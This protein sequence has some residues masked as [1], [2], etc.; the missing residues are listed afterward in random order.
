MCL[1]QFY[2][3]IKIKFMKFGFEMRIYA[4]KS[5]F[6]FFLNCPISANHTNTG[7][8]NLSGWLWC[9]YHKFN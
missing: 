4:Q 1:L 3:V 2:L 9:F 6:F 8:L 7:M 5:V